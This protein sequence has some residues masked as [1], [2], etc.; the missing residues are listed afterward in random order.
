[1]KNIVLN[2]L[3]TL[4][5]LSALRLAQNHVDKADILED[6][7]NATALLASKHREADEGFEEIFYGP[8]DK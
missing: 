3:E 2:E 6:I 5:I 1:M 7:R 4:Y 8:Y